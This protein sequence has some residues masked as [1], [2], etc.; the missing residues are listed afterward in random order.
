MG[1]WLTREER[2]EARRGA[3]AHSMKE[4]SAHVVGERIGTCA[5]EFAS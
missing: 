2:R 5:A 1:V 3:C 4:A